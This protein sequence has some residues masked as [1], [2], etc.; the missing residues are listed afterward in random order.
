MSKLKVANPV[1]ENV[2][3]EG[4]KEHVYNDCQT[5]RL[6]L[7]ALNNTATNLYMCAMGYLAMYATGIGGL[8]VTVVGFIL[9]AMRMFDGFTDPVVG[10]IIDKTDGK[11]GKFRPFMVIGN[12]IL[13]IMTFTIFTTVH[14]VPQNMRLVYFVGCY[15]IY[16]IGYTCQTACTKAGQACMTNNPEKR[17]KFGLFDAM[18]N[19]VLF[20]GMQV[21]VASYLVPKHGGFGELGLYQELITF[22]IITSAILTSLAVFGIWKKDRTEF[23]GLGSKSVKIK[24]R[25]YWPVL[26]GNRGLQMLIVAACTDKIA[27]SVAGNATVS[28]MLFGIVMG[29]YALAGSIGMVVLIPNIIITMMGTKYAQKLGQKKALVAGTIV[30]MIAYTVLVAILVIGDPTQISLKNMGMMTISFLVVY[31]IARGATGV[32]GAFVIPMISDCADY[33]TYLSGRFV[34]GMMGTL[35]SFIDKLISSLATT[36]IALSVASIGFVDRMP[37]VTDTSSPEL[38]ALTLFL[39]AGMPMIGWICSL[40]AMKFYPLD[41]AKMEEVQDHIQ[42]LKKADTQLA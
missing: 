33:E 16:I 15:A 22:V 13:G 5:W 20:T 40:I 11:F 3:G 31:I 19:A 29:D 35:F 17:P 8:L 21:Y 1:L 4:K 37:D 42:E 36:I 39:F 38:F 28:I 2:G 24:F 12:I 10:Y 26:K 32:S 18:Y 41:K 25:D 9:T 34:P 23:F 6:A 7:F 14:L 30:S 27:L